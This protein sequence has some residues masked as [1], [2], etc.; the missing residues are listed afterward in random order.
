MPPTAC[1]AR[2][3][4]GGFRRRITA[5]DLCFPSREA[6]KRAIASDAVRTG[7]LSRVRRILP[8]LAEGDVLRWEFGAYVAA[9]HPRDAGFTGRTARAR[10]ACNGGGFRRSP[11]AADLLLT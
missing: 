8:G 6:A 9:L 7:F 1:G 11:A 4:S 5:S 10:L 2:P 3:R